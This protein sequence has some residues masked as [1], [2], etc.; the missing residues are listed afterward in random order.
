MKDEVTVP[1]WTWISAILLFLFILG[2][3]VS[4]RDR[5]N[6]PILLLPDVK[7]VVDYRGSIVSWHKRLKGL[8]ARL[9]R[10]L[11]DDYRGDLFTQ[12]SEGQDILDGTLQLLNEIEQTP[13]P[14]AAAPA[15]DLAVAGGT[16]YLNAARAT[17][18]WISAPTPANLDSAQQ[19][20]A[21][22]RSAMS[23][24]EA[25]QWMAKTGR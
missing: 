25:S 17:L 13:A 2:F 20:L 1:K 12:A 18:E 23:D 8:D 22:A 5:N 11:S 10:I 7:S 14:A 15:R 6:R 3:I 4:P 24:L 9:A 21:A 19:A 16:A